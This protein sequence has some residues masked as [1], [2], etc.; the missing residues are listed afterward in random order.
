MEPL[1]GKYEYV[2][3][4]VFNRLESDSR[5]NL[6]RKATQI[7]SI[8]LWVIRGGAGKLVIITDPFVLV[9][10]RQE[11]RLYCA[12]ALHLAHTSKKSP[13]ATTV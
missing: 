1:R 8:A 7:K 13:F 3:L 2:N 11:K 5:L 12:A 10:P 9:L 4:V 6:D